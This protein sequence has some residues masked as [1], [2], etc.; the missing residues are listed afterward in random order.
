MVKLNRI[1]I[2]G[3]HKVRR[4]DY[5]LDNLTYFYGDNGV[6]KSTVLQAIQLALLGYIPGSPKNNEGIFRHA[7]SH[8]MAVTL[9]LTDDSH[10]VKIQRIWTKS[11]KISSSVNVTPE[12]YDIDAILHNIELPIF[13]FSDFL[14]QSANKLKDW[15]ISF[16]PKPDVNIDWR[17]RFKDYISDIPEELQAELLEDI[18]QNLDIH[19]GATSLSDVIAMNE[20]LKSVLSFYKYSKTRL[21]NSVT[22]LVHYDLPEDEDEDE[23]SQKLSALKST[24]ESA[25][26]IQV[27]QQ[28]NAEV[29]KMLEQYS[30]L[31]DD[32]SEDSTIAQYKKSRINLSNDHA[33]IL[34]DMQDIKSKIVEYKHNISELTPI[35]N[36]EGRCPYTNSICSEIKI[37]EQEYRVQAS[38]YKDKIAELEGQLSALNQMNV[39]LRDDISKLTS[40]II[41]SEQRYKSRDSLRNRIVEI[42]QS[43]SIVDVDMTLINTQIWEIQNKLAQISAN[44]QYDE[45]I[46]KFTSDKFKIELKIAAISKLIKDT[47]SNGLQNDIMAAPFIDLESTMTKYISVLFNNDNI[48]AKF[49]LDSKSNSFSFGI[50]R[51]DVYVCYDLLSS[52]EKCIFAI[53]L[54]ISLMHCNNSGFCT[55]L[56]DDMLDHLDDS[57]INNLSVNISKISDVQIICA[58]VKTISNV[59]SPINCILIK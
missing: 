43:P 38:E 58:G 37:L 33:K 21:D 56:I 19:Q 12:G 55:L 2:E 57:A 24:Y 39:K 34:S 1:T 44:K 16:L 14:N 47:S 41:V 35:I 45:V 42:E 49:N 22:S 28:A 4:R 7:N 27:N 46:N 51:D 15:F 6:G 11:T 5:N 32:V 36:G 52:G 17:D 3:M 23:L 29:Y 8:T 20:N 40:N 53:A 31:A 18:F 48:S 50:I 59:D 30:D 9:Y 26:N 13:N 10:P 54:M 25:H